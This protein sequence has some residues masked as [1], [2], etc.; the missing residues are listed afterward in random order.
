[1]S[2]IWKEARLE[3]EQIFWK[4]VFLALRVKTHKGWRKDEKIVEKIL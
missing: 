3:L 1:L 2:K 4:K